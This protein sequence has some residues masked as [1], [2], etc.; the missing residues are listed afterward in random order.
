MPFPQHVENLDISNKL[1][2]QHSNQKKKGN[3]K[4]G[5]RNQLLA[6]KEPPVEVIKVVFC[7]N[8]LKKYYNISL[9]KSAYCTLIWSSKHLK[10]KK[11]MN[12]SEHFRKQSDG[13]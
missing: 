2:L 3:M 4:V 9:L 6:E 1:D 12:I 10:K 11:A 8:W 13:V 7:P 5:S